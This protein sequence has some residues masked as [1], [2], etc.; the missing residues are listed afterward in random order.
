MPSAFAFNFVKL[1]GSL[2]TSISAPNFDH[3]EKQQPLATGGTLHQTG[4]AVIRTAPMA[5][6][7]TLAVRA[8]FIALGTGDEVPF[9]ALDGAN[10]IELLGGKGSTTAPGYAAATPHARRQMISGDCYLK[11]VS[12]RSGDV[13]RAE[14]E[15]FGIGATGT[16]NPVVSDTTS[17]TLPTNTEQL[18]VSSFTVGGTEI[19][20]LVGFDLDITH[21]GENSDEETCYNKGLQYPVLTKRAG[22]GGQ[23]EILLTYETLDLTTAISNGTT[24]ITMAVLNNLGIGLSANTAIITL[25]SNLIR[26]QVIPG[27]DGQPAKR[28]VQVRAT[29]N[30]STLPIAITTA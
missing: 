24:V 8:L 9:V 5:S 6:F 21:Q 29:Y 20:S 18:A 30:G 28:R 13:A 26:E 7:T 4:A 12:W 1:N 25:S 16:T 15:V 2:L 14:V 27:E 11:R 22:P 10:G 3:R 23:T 19:D 17:L